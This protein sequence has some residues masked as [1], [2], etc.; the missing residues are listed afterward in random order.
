[1]ASL[2]L[3]PVAPWP[4]PLLLVAVAGVLIWWPA[5]TS[6]APQPLLGQLRRSGAVILLLVAALRPGLP[7]G[8][9]TLASTD[10]D[11]FFVVDTTSSMVAQD[12]DSHR[13]RLDGARAD[14][15]AIAADLPGSRFSLLTFDHETVTRLPLTTDS[16]ALTTAMEVLQVETS[17]YSQGSSITVAGPDLD[18]TLQRDR[19]AHPD[20]ARVV[21][22]LGDGE[23]TASGQPTPFELGADLV[24]GGA[25][26]GYGTSQGGQMKETGTGRDGFVTDPTTGAP[27]VST[28]DEPA[29]QDIARQLSLPYL[30]R[31]SPRDAPVLDAVRLDPSGVLSPTSSS[32]ASGRLELCWVAL[33]LLALVAAWELAAT[34]AAVRFTTRDSPTPPPVRQRPVVAVP[35][36]PP[37]PPATRP[38]TGGHR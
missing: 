34:L 3:L 26:L 15:A 23:Q 38:R 8:S 17:S 13:P 20:R 29:L 5:G 36:A 31:T 37:V 1:M 6:E 24:A 27:A 21:F 30:H 7:G 18:A 32:S 28:I 16:Q 25:V 11:V 9:V 12:Y 19:Q 33:L 2:S 14:V 22:Y 35:P 4:L 10:L